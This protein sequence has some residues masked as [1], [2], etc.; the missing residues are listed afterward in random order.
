MNAIPFAR[1]TTLEYLQHA[2]IILT[3][4]EEARIE[5]A[6]FGLGALHESGLQLLTYI[7]TERVCAKELVLFPGQTCPEHRR[8]PPDDAD[9]GIR[10]PPSVVHRPSSIDRRPQEERPQQ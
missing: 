1:Q 9:A 3:L 10:R 5:V 2:G 4:Q 7:N 8:L 6:D